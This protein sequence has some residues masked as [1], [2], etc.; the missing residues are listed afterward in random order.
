MLEIKNV[1]T[2]SE[3]DSAKIVG[4]AYKRMVITNSDNPY[5]LNTGIYIVNTENGEV[6]C[7]L[8]HSH[9]SWCEFVDYPG[10]VLGR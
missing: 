10:G 3:A 7:L 9:G 2:L 5:G 8:G 1:K 4:G 6:T